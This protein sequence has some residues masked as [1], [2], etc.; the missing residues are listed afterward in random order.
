M[1]GAS[2]ARTGGIDQ[3]VWEGAEIAV[4]VGDVKKPGKPELH[5]R[6]PDKL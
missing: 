2:I 4:A 1:L 5:C 6:W 3:W